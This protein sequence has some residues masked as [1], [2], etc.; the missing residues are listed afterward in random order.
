MK[1]KQINKTENMLEDVE[2]WNSN[3]TFKDLEL[4]QTTKDASLALYNKYELIPTL[5]KNYFNETGDSVISFKDDPKKRI[6][7]IKCIKQLAVSDLVSKSVKKDIA[8]EFNKESVK[9]RINEKVLEIIYVHKIYPESY[10]Q[11]L[12]DVAISNPEAINEMLKTV[13]KK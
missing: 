7:L 3:K 8:K 4:S 2:V 12:L 5:R 13:S 11:E 10:L 1:L 9:Q 6:N